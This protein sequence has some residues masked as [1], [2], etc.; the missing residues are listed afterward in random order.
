MMDYDDVPKN[1]L[2]SGA[3]TFICGLAGLLI[4]LLANDIAIA[5]LILGALGL[6]VGG[7]AINVANRAIDEQR[8]MY[9]SVAGIGL[10]LSVLAFMIGL[11]TV[12]A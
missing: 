3:I 10:M 7:Y 2:G 1:P 11:A 4:A 8:M 12:V 6:V 5:G 9:L